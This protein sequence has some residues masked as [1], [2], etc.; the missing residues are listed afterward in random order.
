MWYTLPLFIVLSCLS[1]IFWIMGQSLVSGTTTSPTV[2]N[3]FLFVNNG[4]NPF[5]LALLSKAIDH[6]W[7]FAQFCLYRH[8]FNLSFMVKDMARDENVHAFTSSKQF[9]ELCFVTYKMNSPS[10][11]H[12]HPPILKVVWYCHCM[13]AQPCISCVCLTTKFILVYLTFIWIAQLLPFVLT[14]ILWRCGFHSCHVV[15]Y[16]IIVPFL[17]SICICIGPHGLKPIAFTSYCYD[18]W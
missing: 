9:F 5:A 2:F 6:L 11:A 16:I 12:I 13:L 3:L 1:L 10:A 17:D 15:N 7:V 8:S 18:H 4:L 14:M